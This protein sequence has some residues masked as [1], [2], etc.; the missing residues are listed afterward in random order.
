MTGIV[1]GASVGGILG[2]LLATPVTASGR[3][4]LRYIYRKMLGLEPLKS[5]DISPESGTPPSGKWLSSLLSEF[6]RRIR[7]RSPESR[8]DNEEE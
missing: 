2:A 1:I 6:R 4:V 8:Q 5:E 7:S 3:E